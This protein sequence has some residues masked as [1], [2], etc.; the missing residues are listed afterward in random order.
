[1]SSI[2][3]KN[4]PSSFLEHFGKEVEFDQIQGI[5]RDGMDRIQNDE[6]VPTKQDIAGITESKQE[7][8]VSLEEFR[9]SF[10]V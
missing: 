9:S 5:Y 7:E 6:V 4:V 10:P 2:K 3:V 1:M 8:T